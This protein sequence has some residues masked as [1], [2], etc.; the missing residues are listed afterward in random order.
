MIG[1]EKLKGCDKRII[2]LADYLELFAKSKYN[3]ELIITSGKREGEQE[4]GLP[5]F[6]WHNIGLAIDFC[7]KNTIV[8][9]FNSELF[10]LFMRNIA[11]FKSATE[12]EVCKGLCRGVPAQHIHIAFGLESV[13]ESFTGIYPKA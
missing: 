10:D 12:F 2:L 5:G 11:A 13:K 9:Y 3:D 1:L 4:R 8:L 6:S 7:F